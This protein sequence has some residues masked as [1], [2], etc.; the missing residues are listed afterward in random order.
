MLPEPAFARL[1][2]ITE[3]LF[4]KNFIVLNPLLIL[5]LLSS[6]I[7]RHPP[8]PISATNRR[9]L[10]EAMPLRNPCQ[11]PP[12]PPNS[13]NPRQHWRFL[14]KKVGVVTPC[15]LISLK[16]GTHV[17]APHPTAGSSSFSVRHR[18]AIPNPWPLILA[19]NRFQFLGAGPFYCGFRFS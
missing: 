8:T 7:P 10:A 12:A 14:S 15:H 2:V 9:G 11:P 17:P 5:L 16:I 13:Q 18:S 1:E 6:V 19:T 4:P 3:A